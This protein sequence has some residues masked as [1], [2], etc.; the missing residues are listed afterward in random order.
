[1]EGPK[2]MSLSGH[3][4]HKGIVSVGRQNLSKEVR[5]DMEKKAQCVYILKY[6]LRAAYLSSDYADVAHTVHSPD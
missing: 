5:G 3:P 6:N 1:M 4:P 2:L